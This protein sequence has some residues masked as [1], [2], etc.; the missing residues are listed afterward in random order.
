AQLFLWAE[1]VATACFTQNHSIIRLHHDKTPYEL[2]H[3]KLP[4][5]SYF[6]VFGE[7]C[8]STNDSENLGKLQPKADI[9]I[10]IGYAPIKKA[11]W[12]YNRRTRRIMETTHVDF[13]ELIA[14]ASEQS[15]SGPALHEMTPATISSGLMPKPNSSTPFVPPLRTN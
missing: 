13:D 10:F 12:I 5:L 3:D 9:G 11:F 6:H 1:A 4:D 14:M 7:L 8:Y 15:S 2:L